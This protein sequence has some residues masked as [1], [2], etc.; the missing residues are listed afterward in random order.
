MLSVAVFFIVIALLLNPSFISCKQTSDEKNSKQSCTIR[1]MAFGL[2]TAGLG[3]EGREQPGS[4]P[5]RL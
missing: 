3:K 2:D 1:G 4:S 5:G